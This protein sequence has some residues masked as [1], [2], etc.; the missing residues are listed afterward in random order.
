MA[1]DDD[2]ADRSRPRVDPITRLALLKAHEAEPHTPIA[3]LADRYG[4]SESTARRFIAG[5]SSD[6]KATV[7]QLMESGA[8]VQLAHWE[9][10]NEIAAARGYFQGSAA[11]LEAAGL[12]QTKPAVAVSVAAPTVVLSMPFGLGALRDYR[13]A[14]A[15]GVSTPTTIEAESVGVPA[16]PAAPLTLTDG[17]DSHG[18]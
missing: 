7:R 16:L 11:Y 3:V 12:V 14:D 15:A 4:M 2:G 5:N 8:V 1:H 17:N 13:P 10:A 9:Q 18:E 6:V